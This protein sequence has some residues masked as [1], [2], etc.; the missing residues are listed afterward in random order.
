M[1]IN[2]SEIFEKFAD[3]AAGKADAA[4]RIR[5]GIDPYPPSPSQLDA[6]ATAEFLEKAAP[7]SGGG[8]I[9]CC[10]AHDDNNPSLSI[11][12]KDDGSGV[13]VHCHAD[14]S[15]AAVIEALRKLGAW[16]SASTPRVER[17]SY[18]DGSG[19]LVTVCRSRKADGTKS[20]WRDP[21]GVTKPAKGWPFYQ[22]RGLDSVPSDAA[23]LIV[24]G[25]RTAEAAQKLFKRYAVT[26]TLGGSS[27]S[28][29]SLDLSPTKDQDVIIWPDN[30]DAG[31]KHAQKLAKAIHPIAKSVRVVVV[32]AELPEKWDLADRLPQGSKLDLRTV[33][34]DAPAWEEDSKVIKLF[35]GKAII[36]QGG[37]ETTVQWLLPKWLPKGML[38][39]LDGDPG[40]GKTL[41]GLDIAAKLSRK[42][43]NT[44]IV[45]DEDDWNATVLPRFRLCGGDGGDRSRLFHLKGVQDENGDMALPDLSQWP[46][47]AEAIKE[48]DISLLIVDPVMAFMPTGAD[49]NSVTDAMRNM[50]SLSYLAAETGVAVIAVRHLNKSGGVRALYRGGGSIAIM[51][52]ARMAWMVIKH[53]DKEGVMLWCM[54]KNSLGPLEQTWEYSIEKVVEI[55]GTADQDEVS[56]PRLILDLAPSPLSADQALAGPKKDNK[57]GRCMTTLEQLLEANAEKGL[58][59]KDAVDSF[60]L[61][62]FSKPT[63]K[64]AYQD[65][66]YVSRKLKGGVYYLVAR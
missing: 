8:W 37:E 20:V 54:I 58:R 47:W 45:G 49:S 23:I 26:T 32:P 6:E 9:A 31:R 18:R 12:D 3:T 2:G 48:H 46:V 25:E 35:P 30:D 29:S 10:P 15:Q 39:V 4:H 40:A 14:C 27:A 55:P 19:V 43:K 1:K 11:N 57:L 65:L 66:G 44:L 21:K 34:D 63:I 50:G 64:R 62:E 38:T 24:E 36:V 7:Q 42:G 51:G 22:L 52:K 5:D 59:T 17:Y 16:S 13:L 33:L 41:I 56:F 60:E 61:D 53:P 28:V